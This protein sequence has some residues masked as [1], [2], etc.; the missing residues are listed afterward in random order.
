MRKA[1][2]Y[3][4]LVLFFGVDIYAQSSR[5]EIDLNEKFYLYWGW[6]RDWYSNSNIHMKGSDYDFTLN[7]VTAS[8][9]QRPFTFKEYL[10]SSYS[11]V[12]QTNLK[13]GYY[14]NKKYS[15]A[16]GFDHMKYVVDW[17]QQV[18]ITG[19]IDR[20][21]SSYKGDYQN[22]SVT[23]LRHFLR[24]EHTDGL[25][26]VFVE[27]NRHDQLFKWKKAR[28]VVSTETGVGV[29]LLRPRTD[30]RFLDKRGP[31]VYHNAGYGLNAK[32]GVNILLFNHVSI[33][34]EAKAGYINM[35]KIQATTD[36]EDLASQHFWFLQSNILIGATF[37]LW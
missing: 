2:I 33:M 21:G 17:D 31:N 16:A 11:S 18:E 22:D 35:P 27:V 5:K 15:I 13:V 30:V 23:L 12:P 14:L 32:V 6:N 36:K 26:Y 7:N 25:N 9:R 24:Y 8:D 20:D 1:I 4:S 19:S 29:G 3:V 10:F 37:G 28:M 34:T